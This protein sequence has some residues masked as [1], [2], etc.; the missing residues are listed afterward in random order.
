MKWDHKALHRRRLWAPRLLANG[1]PRR[2]DSHPKIKGVV[3]YSA[4]LKISRSTSPQV[5]FP[6]EIVARKA[7][8]TLSYYL[9]GALNRR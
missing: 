1:L 6:I 8:N 3:N 9:K 4:A 7:I 2:R 5:I